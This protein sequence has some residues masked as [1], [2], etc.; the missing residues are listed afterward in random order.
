VDR[1]KIWLFTG[2]GD[3]PPPEYNDLVLCRD[4][5]HCTPNELDEQD[6]QTVQLHILMHNAEQEELS[7]KQGGTKR[8]SKGKGKPKG[9]KSP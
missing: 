8:K 3:G 2:G 9:K 7:R 4:I 5:Y 6:A 1:L